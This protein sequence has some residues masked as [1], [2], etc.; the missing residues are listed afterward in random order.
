MEQESVGQ[1]EERREW[2]VR[3]ADEVDLEPGSITAEVLGVD[4]LP[5]SLGYVETPELRALRADWVEAIRAGAENVRE[6]AV[7]YQ[8]RAEAL[9]AEHLE[10]FRRG[11]ALVYAWM[12][13]ETEPGGGED[14]AT[15]L[16][17]AA[18]LGFVET[19]EMRALRARIS[20][21]LAGDPTEQA[22]LL[23]LAGQVLDYSRLANREESVYGARFQ[24]GLLIA[25]ATVQRDGGELDYYH[26]DLGDAQDYA[27][28]MGLAHVVM[29]IDWG[30]N[31]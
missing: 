28:G 17:E 3:R 18:A 24:I 10:N 14:G 30:L 15:V 6:F 27:D 4:E 23:V 29:A 22:P 9:D 2:V 7:A 8:E 13:R 16:A 19:D 20:V 21:T 1:P 5:E 31:S 11:R 25:K 26:E 12:T